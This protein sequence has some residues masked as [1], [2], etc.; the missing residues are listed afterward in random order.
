MSKGEAKVENANYGPE[1]Y[2]EMAGC[3]LQGHLVHQKG[4]VVYAN[5]A[6][7]IALSNKGASIDGKMIDDLFGIDVATAIVS[8]AERPAGS[9]LEVKLNRKGSP[10][11]CFLTRTRLISWQGTPAMETLLLDITRERNAETALAGAQKLKAIGQLTGQV[12]HDFNNVWGV[13]AGNLELLEDELSSATNYE[14]YLS[15]SNRAIARGAELTKELLSYI[16]AHDEGPVAVNVETTVENMRG[17]IARTVGNNVEFEIKFEEDLWL[18]FADQDEF[19]HALLNLAN[20]AG[21]AMQEGGTYLIEGRKCTVDQA[22]SD[23]TLVPA[24]DWIALA[25]SD[26]GCGMSQAT[27]DQAFEPF[28]TTKIDGS[29]NGLGLSQVRDFVSRQG[30]YVT[31]QSNVAPEPRQGTT[32]T[33]YFPRPMAAQVQRPKT[34]STARSLPKPTAAA[35]APTTSAGAISVM[36]VEVDRA[37][38]SMATMMLQRQDYI[39]HEAAGMTGASALLERL[40]S[41]DL[42]VVDVTLTPNSSGAD[43]IAM[44]RE[45]FGDIST[46]FIASNNDEPEHQTL[47]ENSGAP[48]LNKP[49]HQQELAKALKNIL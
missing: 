30:G 26:T 39:V 20:N 14:Q 32:L 44:A 4:S 2:H 27:I 9:T 47:T 5:Q 24:G 31:L 19:E 29:G 45:K 46:L 49:F 8:S 11:S 3:S 22:M 33:L 40:E 38:R 21:E 42:L 48:C 1:L 35:L 28:F 36:I 17:L 10:P 41:L 25:F 16:R 18:V 34:E 43:V 6:A 15:A 7:I 37:L 23:A 12:A 13:I